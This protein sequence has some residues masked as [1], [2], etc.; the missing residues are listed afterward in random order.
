MAHRLP[1]WPLIALLLWGLVILLP[2][3]TGSQLI[4]R[5]FTFANQTW[6]LPITPKQATTQY[7]FTFRRP[8]FYGGRV[9][10]GG[11]AHIEF[12]YS[13]DDEL[14]SWDVPN[15]DSLLFS[16]RVAHTYCFVF[17]D[18]L[19]RY[20]SVKTVLERSIGKPFKVYDD[21][22]RVS[23]KVREVMF[24]KGQVRYELLQ[25]DDSTFIALR[26]RPRQ[27]AYY[28]SYL[29]VLFFWGCSREAMFHRLR[30]F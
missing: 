11:K 4:P 30:V 5:Y 26:H 12:P 17:S 19:S 16:N 20:D 13:V 7:G 22:M 29:E 21:S 8:N 9:I 2:A 1:K 6:V 14:I 25:R 27:A 24:S 3:H 23:K 10:D 15:P 28:P 18:T